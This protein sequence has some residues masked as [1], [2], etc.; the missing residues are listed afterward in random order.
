M[1][2]GE[3]DRKAQSQHESFDVLERE[4]GIRRNDTTTM[5][6][7][8][9]NIE[10]KLI[11]LLNGVARIFD[12]IRCDAA[13]VLELLGDSSALDS[14]TD[15]R[16]SATSKQPITVHNVQLFLG[17]VRRRAQV[18][19]N[20]VNMTELPAG[21]KVLARKDRVPKFNVKETAKSSSTTPGG[22]R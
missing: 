11:D 2:R 12:L 1:Q 15:G 14:L 19:I 16:V 6:T 4:L 9:L 5:R 7:I 17:V 13:P 8:Q 3:N 10:Q 18:I 22:K 21:V 20:T